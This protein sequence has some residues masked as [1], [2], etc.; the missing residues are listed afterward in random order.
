MLLLVFTKSMCK[1]FQHMLANLLISLF[2]SFN[3]VWEYNFIHIISGL[4]FCV[5]VFVLIILDVLNQCF[6]D[7]RTST[8]LKG[9]AIILKYVP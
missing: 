7:M 1:Y 9:H 2:W 3:Y 5:F 6:I 4:E 8:N